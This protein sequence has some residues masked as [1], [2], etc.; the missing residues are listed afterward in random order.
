VWDFFESY[1]PL[2]AAKEKRVSG[3]EPD[4]VEPLSVVTPFGTL[5]GGYFPV[6]YDTRAS[7]R[8]EQHA[9]AE[10]ARSQMHAAY[11]SATTRRS[12]T[13]ARAKE[14]VERPLMLSFDGIF[15]GANEVIHDLAW[16]EWL[17][18]VNRLIKNKAVDK[19]IRDRYGADV[20]KQFKSSFEDIAR[21][22]A[23][24]Q[25]GLER[26]LNHLRTGATI[27]GL[28]WNLMTSML[29]PLGLT[30]SMVRVGPKWV[31]QG[32]GRTLGN[33][34]EALRTIYEKSEFMRIR[35][36]TMQRE[37]NEIQNQVSGKSDARLAI[38]AS[39]FVL[40]QK[41]QLMAD[42][43][44]WHGAY[45]K[46]IAAGEADERAVAL[47][48]QA[49]IDSQGGGQLKDLSAVQRGGP[50]LKLFTNFY[51]YFNVSYNL[52]A[53]RA[54]AT[55]FKSAKSVGSLAVDYLLLFTVP[56][57]LGALL[58][59]AVLGGDD[60]DDDTLARKLA[61]EQISYLFGTMVGLRELTSAAQYFTG[62]KV[63]P[64]TYSGPAG[65]RFFSEMEKLGKQVAQGE[66]DMAL[67]RAAANALGIALHLPSGQAVRTVEGA[68]ALMEGDTANPLVLATGT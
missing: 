37:I 38:E 11:T 49:V 48:D 32:I 43:P 50:A 26:A 46:A 8:A 60:D 18:D 34:A 21:G 14:V 22:D 52:A 65:L 29:Q 20:I 64:T 63:I 5:R 10:A 23:P 7:A 13:K 36:K 44:T 25:N 35:G 30:Q 9:D 56:A 67:F 39:F 45:D 24:A 41:A 55:D 66:V 51:S 33:P 16:H 4:W 54:R 3:V 19:A 53:E 12:F 15:Q 2:I 28:G 6:K 42:V 68:T 58:K 40:I 47:A 59:S 31:A 1:R 61:G 27:A 62:T 57:V 17:I